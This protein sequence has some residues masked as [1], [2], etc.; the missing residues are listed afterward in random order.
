MAMCEKLEK[1][2]FYQGK[3]TM[4]S[5]IGSMFKKKYC[6]GGK[7]ICA[8]Y[9]VATTLGPNFV[10]GTLFPNMNDRAKAILAENGK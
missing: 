5:G 9:I 3:M 10:P 6:E 7:T 2:P 4:D 1:C 8:R